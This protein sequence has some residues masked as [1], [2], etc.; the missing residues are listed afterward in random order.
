MARQLTPKQKKLVDIIVSNS[1][2]TKITKSKADMMVEAGYSSKTAI[3][4]HRII[5][6]D[7]MQS[8]LQQRT[9]KTVDEF[10][11]VRALALARLPK[12]IG[13]APYN[14]LV[15][16]IDIFTKNIQLLSGRATENKAIH[17]QISEHIAR[18]NDDD[19][20][21]AIVTSEIINEAIE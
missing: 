20:V 12:K 10:E 13:S 17:I 14:H 2:E 4:P 19:P 7:L 11:R 8:E 5:D 15:N 6:T 3:N 21:S 16:S 1:L 18:K 9:Q